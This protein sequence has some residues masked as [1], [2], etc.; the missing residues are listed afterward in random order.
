MRVVFSASDPHQ[1]CAVSASSMS[2][3]DP[4]IV[5]WSGERRELVAVDGSLAELPAL[6][7]DIGGTTASRF[8]LVV[9]PGG[10]PVGE[11]T[12]FLQRHQAAF[13]AIHI[14]SHGG[15]G[16]IALGGQT[17]ALDAIGQNAA[18][19]DSI[20]SSIVVGGDLLIYG[21]NVGT[22]VASQETVSRLAD[23]TGADVAVST[24][25]T[26]AS[27]DWVLEYSTGRIEAATINA[28]DYPDDL[29]VIPPAN[30]LTLPAPYS[31][32]WGAT[33]SL[34]STTSTQ[35]VIDTTYGVLEGAWFGQDAGG[36]ASLT[37]RVTYNNRANTSA[38]LTPLDLTLG[39]NVGGPGIRFTMVETN[40]GSVQTS[41]DVT[42]N[43]YASAV[44]NDDYFLSTVQVSGTNGLALNYLRTNAVASKT[45]VSVLDPTLTAAN[46]GPLPAV[47][48]TLNNTGAKLAL[49]LYDTTTQTLT[50]LSPNDIAID[51]GTTPAYTLLTR[52]DLK[53]GANYELRFYV[54]R[55][56]AS[57][58]TVYVDNPLLYAVINELPTARA[59]AFT[60]FVTAPVSGNLITANNGSGVDTDPESQPLGIVQIDGANYTVGSPISTANGTLTITNADGGFTYTA[61]PGFTG[62]DSFTYTIADSV[63]GKSTATVTMTVNQPVTV[64]DITVNEGSP[65]AVFTVSASQGQVMTLALAAGTATGG[66][67]DYGGTTN[68]AN[69]L[70][71]SLDGGTT[72]TTYT[73]SFT[74]TRTG[75][76]IASGVLVRTKITNDSIADNGETF[77]LTV[78]PQGGAAAT[79][80]ATI[81]DD[82]TGDIFATNGTVDPNAVRDGD[83][84]LS[85][86][87]LIVNE[88]TPHA[89]WTVK[90]VAGQQINLDLVYD[91]TAVAADLNAAAAPMLQYYNTS[92]NAW[93]NY[94]PGSGTAVTIPTGGKLLVRTTVEND[95]P[96]EVSEVL[97][98]KVVDANA[99]VGTVRD[100]PNTTTMDV[101]VVANAATLNLNKNLILNSDFSQYSM[102]VPGQ[103]WGRYKVDLAAWAESGGGL[104]TYALPNEGI[105]GFYFG[106]YYGWSTSQYGNGLPP[107]NSDDVW[108]GTL[109]FSNTISNLYGNN[110]IPVAIT[111]N[112]STE[113]GQRY[114]L[115]FTQS[116]EYNGNP[117]G[118]AALEVGGQRVFFKVYSAT[119]KVYTFEFVA[120][121]TTTPIAFMSWGHLGTNTSSYTDELLLIQPI[122]N[123]VESVTGT[124]TI[125]D[126]GQGDLFSAT[127]TT[128]LPDLPGTNG[129][130]ATLNDDRG[131]NPVV[132]DVTVNEGSPY[133]V[134]TVDGLPGAKVDLTIS[135]AGGAGAADLSADLSGWEWSNDGGQTWQSDLSAAELSATTG[136]MLVRFVPTN[137]TALETSEAFTLKAQ[138]AA[139]QPQG[140]TINLDPNTNFD[141][142]IG[143][144]K[145]DGTG[146]WYAGTSGT[147]SP[148][149]PAG[150]ALND[151]R[152]LT[153]NS[154][155]AN[156]ASPFMVFQVTG[157]V[158][159]LV[160]LALDTTGTGAGHAD[161]TADLQNAGTGVPLQVYNGTAWVDYTPGS[162]VAIPAGN[163]GTMLVRTKLVNDTAYEASETYLLTASN[164][165]AT[166]KNAATPGSVLPTASGTGTITDDGTGSLFSG[167][168]TTGT[169]EAPGT[170]GLPSVLNNDR[171]I[172][173]NDISVNEGSPYGVFTVGD[174]GGRSITLALANGTATGTGTDYGAA[175]TVTTVGQSNLEYSL[176]GGTTWVRYTAAFT[177]TLTGAGTTSGL[178]VRT[179]IKNDSIFDNGETYTLTATPAGGNAVVG[180]ATIHDDGTGQW[181]S[182]TSG[183]GS[184]SAPAGQNLDGDMPLSVNN[185]VV[186]EGSPYAVWTVVYGAGKQVSL[187]LS[188]G[189]ASVA[190]D[191]LPY[192]GGH[193]METSVDGGTTWTPYVA[194]SSA[195]IGADSKLLVRVR[196]NDDTPYE[197]SEVLNLTVVKATAGTVSDITGTATPNVDFVAHAATLDASASVNLVSNGLFIPQGG[198]QVGVM[199]S[200]NYAPQ[201]DKIPYW[202]ASGGGTA[203]YAAAIPPGNVPVAFSTV[204]IYFGNGVF[205]Q[206]T[207]IVFDANGAIAGDYTFTLD[208]T[209]GN[210][211]SPVAI[212]QSIP[213]EVG[214]VYRLQFTQG[215]E[216]GS[217][218]APGMAAVEIGDQRIYFR[219]NYANTVY[220]F[221]FTAT[222]AYTPIKFMNWGHATVNWNSVT[223]LALNNVIVNKLDS[224]T[225]T[226]TI[227]DN[228]QGSTFSG[229]SATP[230]ATPPAPLNDDRVNN[231]VVNDISVNE[232]S[233]YAVFTVDGLPGAYV[234]LALAE[235]A[236]AAG[237]TPNSDIDATVLEYSADGTTW[238]AYDA[239]TPPALNADGKL[240][241]RTSPINDTA[242]EQSETITLTATYAGGKDSTI[243]PSLVSPITG[244]TD[245]GVG[246]ILDNG[247]GLWFDGTGADAGTGSAT[248]PAGSSLNDD[249]VIAVNSIGVNEASPYA[250]F[251]VTATAGQTVSSLA[252]AA[253]TATGGGTD[254]GSG[255]TPADN[256]QYSID[257]GLTW[258]TYTAGASFAVPTKDAAGATVAAG[259]P[260]GA[261]LVRTKIIND[262]PFD[263]GETFTLTAALAGGQTATGTGTIFDDGTGTVFNNDGTVNA[264]AA[265]SDDRGA[266]PVV[267]DVS[268]N[269][270]S[271]FVV[272]LVEGK[273]GAE[274]QL[275]LVFATPAAGKAAD[276]DLVAAGSPALE[277]FDGSDW[278]P[279]DPAAKPVIPASTGGKLFV[280]TTVVNDAVNEGPETF[281]LNATY[282]AG[283]INTGLGVTAGAND[284]GVATILDRGTGTVF[285]ADD[286]ATPETDESAPAAAAVNGVATVAAPT[287][288]PATGSLVP[289]A[290][291][292]RLP[293]DDRPVTVAGFIVNEASPYGIFTVTG[294]TGQYV[295][296]A[297]ADGTAVGG[298]TSPT[299]GSVDYNSALEY[300]DG[301]AWQ[302]Y[303]PGGFVQ[304]P[305]TG[306]TLLVRT[307]IVN[308]TSFEGSQSLTLTAANTQG[309]ASAPATGTILDN[310]TGSLFAASNT[311]GTPD[312]PGTNGLPATLNDDRVANPS[313]NSVTVNEASPFIVFTVSGM[314]GAGVAIAMT[315]DTATGVG[316]AVLG[317]DTAATSV[318][319]V[320]RNG[321]WV[322]ATD[323]TSIIN[324]DGTLLVR[325]AVTNDTP[326]VYEGPETF[327]ISAAYNGL[328]SPVAP[329]TVGG[330]AT[331]VGTIVDNGTG[332]LFSS[333]NATGAPEAAGTNGLPATLDN[334]KPGFSVNDVTV[335]EADGTITF[336]V[337][338]TGTSVAN[339]T[340][341]YATA[342]GTAT[343]ADADY[344]ATNGTLTFAPGET[345]KTVNVPIADNATYEGA[346][347]LTL[348]L[349][350]PTGGAMIADA[351]GVGTI[352]DPEDQPTISI[353]DVQVIEATDAYAVMT[354]SLSAAAAV[355]MSFTPSLAN[356][357]SGPGYAIVGTDTQSTPSGAAIEYFNG[358]AWVTAAGGVTI[359]AGQ[360]S[361]QV[362]SAI[363]MNDG[364]GEPIETYSLRTNTVTF[365][366]GGAAV[367]A[368]GV[369][370]TVT[371]IDNPTMSISSVTVN[372]GSPYAVVAVSLS[373][374]ATSAITFT[375]SLADGTAGGG[376][377]SGTAGTDTGGGVEYFNGTAWVSAA[378]GVTIP[379]G[380]TG[381]LLRAAITQDTLNETSEVVNISTGPATN[382]LNPSGVTGTITIKD[383]ATGSL[384]AATNNTATPDNPGTSGLPELFDDD[385]PLAVN[386]I[387]VN[388]GSPYAVFT[389]TGQP[390]QLVSLTLGNT[391][392]NADVDAI[393]GTDTANAG[394]IVPLQ[395]FN[396]TSWVDYIPGS[397]VAIPASGTT[398]LVR[399][400]ITNDTPA[401][402]EGP[403]TFTLTATNT[404]TTPATGTCTILDNGVGDVFSGVNVTGL[405]E[406]PGTNGLPPRLDDDRPLAVNSITVNEASP[407]AVF[408]VTGQPGQLVTLVL[409]N[410]SDPSDRDATLGTD[411]GNAGS[412]VPLQYFNGTSWVDYVPGSFVAIPSTGATLRVRTAIVNDNPFE[413][414]ET[415]TL[416]ATN[417]GGG[418]ATG[419]ATILDNGTGGIYLPANTSG[420][421]DAPGTPG[422][423]RSLDDDMPLVVTVT[424]ADCSSGPQVMVVDPFTGLPRLQ[425][426]VFEPTFRGGARAGVG[427]VNGD[428]DEEIVVS[429]GPGRT[430]EIRVFRKDGTELVA[431]RTLP[432]GPRNMGGV[433]VAVGDVDGDG[434]ADIV[435][436]ASMGPGTTAVFRV[437]PTAADPVG[438][439]P[440]K[441]FNAFGPKVV[442][443]G[444]V[445]VA[446]LN[447]DG[448][449]EIIRGSGLGARP[450]VTVYDLTGTPRVLD[451]FAPFAGLK[452]YTGGVSV[453]ATWFNADATPDIIVAGGQGAGSVVEVY[454]GT[455]NA[456]V[457]NARLDTARLSAFA[458]LGSRNVAVFAAGVDLDGDGVVDRL[459]TTQGAGGSNRG[460]R[461]V[462]KTGVIAE[463]PATNRSNLR[464][465][466]S[467]P[468]R[469]R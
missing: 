106:N 23:R 158:G 233:P 462:T 128:G 309:T 97:S 12:G 175:S 239:A 81:T 386:S 328:G 436:V 237:T 257:G 4:L 329:I 428:G 38:N 17:L 222:D 161:L 270:G 218:Y 427:D 50:R 14:V 431:Y 125:L 190:N 85:V 448:R 179:P 266:N 288:T 224:V 298:S 99:T 415:F 295:T 337:T 55:T 20:A 206:T 234:S 216:V 397:F 135:T 325:L 123:K 319:E 110:N 419:I 276:A 139:S 43:S 75:G 53:A 263:N 318:L 205:S 407:Y 297:L 172:T 54:W 100:I 148:T 468:K 88:G 382:V 212:Q 229:S 152:P 343:L 402:F 61:N 117:D 389:V 215:Y 103:P 1:E 142:G 187:G 204:G 102:N 302:A 168:N 316:H 314:P 300:F 3:V 451:S 434:N 278:R 315:N 363:K 336:T 403:E 371:I 466:S 283:T 122:I 280:R 129:A 170:N 357:G 34:T 408:T 154:V 411:T 80:T 312:S 146:Q 292:G 246:T 365:G 361:V 13:D 22:D 323:A 289:V 58:T 259:D 306:T 290:D 151:D 7:G 260:T 6:L 177:V 193:Q 127:N 236:D 186:N 469:A 145:D 269:E 64:N 262:S 352:N 284:S 98:L 455:I 57:D 308:D 355:P 400:K 165:D 244:G 232:A 184:D 230:D 209:F 141:T 255:S 385:R 225:G 18:L 63:G 133:G 250:V 322:A 354:V 134:F 74:A 426:P 421:P 245:T 286:P 461:T 25:V 394:A 249:R 185:L 197:V 277:Y 60:T 228:G 429:S 423:P 198:S 39:P 393:L 62:T 112:I 210:N 131:H 207:P 8:V 338:L 108:V 296:L 36:K 413:N 181:F 56:D 202:T 438:N 238:T 86:N 243:D 366:T 217:N 44:A 374:P 380:A 360:T 140:I 59:D 443:G 113:I 92:T 404:G 446:D 160:S 247:T 440:W 157:T 392:S 441:S 5:A 51:A 252:L 332:S 84:P 372:E 387:T 358:T 395:Y 433:E 405:P 367:T 447:S 109:T 76:G 69:N 268:V 432:F 416:T 279:Y 45:L 444:S 32:V 111:Q 264:A 121:S 420:V 41:V 72:W 167:T 307:A 91:S 188:D 89:V 213:T 130:P 401:A 115:Q 396:G 153:V 453:A 48:A 383:D 320:Y 362:R 124:L 313:V 452:K 191:L 173:V 331:G 294:A 359:P 31:Y 379:V 52:A 261:F 67:T 347:T 373:L 317:T 351:V 439:Q 456:R 303:T 377:G 311:T 304:I 265:K 90:Y 241:V 144:V 381:V 87:N 83:Y 463:T 242:Y 192:A 305:A 126:N 194:G 93:V 19:W 211:A 353:T 330:S 71:Y 399:T 435:A 28:A 155:T 414:A 220:T 226:L 156:E 412:G 73:G 219:V 27:G 339:V 119:N 15:P 200:V 16:W 349:S 342:D 341:D 335:N 388:E 398:M 189:T 326:A 376:S 2:G 24:D 271:P 136:L 227:L 464:I 149:A 310:G 182:G 9:G 442:S 65:Y 340:V 183:T 96:Y 370:G 195:T 70:Q 221:Q 163:G 78:T 406:N 231:P 214:Q 147:G 301:T 47:G 132:N 178:L 321:A 114:R 116:S 356:A 458:D 368:A 369:T 208:P 293:N 171:P 378:G 176:D 150:L 267:G 430:A 273:P 285:V 333:S 120:T 274:M 282:V 422:S 42:S 364:I 327:G 11:L 457:A 30:S 10:D 77:T 29:W 138:Y 344:T 203:S 174:A 334:D 467:L 350:N 95:V 324:A 417:T 180:T 49:A 424:Q 450:L 390:G 445:A 425:F 21:C 346:E 391:A 164:V 449:A 40:D 465:V 159:Q 291:A 281:S 143:T 256:L 454:D 248:A 46:G 162:L 287:V 35:Y 199:W 235:N 104:D 409:G 26:G 105:S 137:D 253:R 166:L 240:F 101:N 272:F 254:Y 384:F 251:T 196:V 460:I 201:G 94:T 299:D 169:P 82:G 437:T 33:A 223:E 79:G 345:T 348:N 68:S 118:I 459:F 410:T 375:P 107:F 37:P 275:D 258:V 66:G 418:P